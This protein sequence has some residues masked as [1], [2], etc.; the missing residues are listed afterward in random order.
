MSGNYDTN[1]RRCLLVML[2]YHSHFENMLRWDVGRRQFDVRLRRAN[3][4]QN[5]R[6]ASADEMSV[7]GNW[8]SVNAIQTLA[9]TWAF[10]VQ[11][12]FFTSIFLFSNVGAILLQYFD[13]FVPIFSGT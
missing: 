5:S 4:T 1:F 12:S 7:N 13:G 2:L 8:K 6:L 9:E 11:I 3:A 10:F